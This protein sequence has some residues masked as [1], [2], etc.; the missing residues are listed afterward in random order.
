MI[1]KAESSTHETTGGTQQPVV[2][3][4]YYLTP[5]QAISRLP[6][7]ATPAQ[8]DSA[9][10]AAFHP[11]EIHYSSRPDT[12][13]LPGE[14]LGKSVYEASIPQYYKETYFT[15]DSLMHPE[16]SGGRMG[17]AGEPIP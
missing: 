3:H 7:D 9:I 17:I 8:Q 12:L 2:H 14:P 6:K 13:R 4:G 11:G 1:L 10:Q 15:S 5:A 16:I